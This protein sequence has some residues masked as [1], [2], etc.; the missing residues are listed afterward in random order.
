MSQWLS[1]PLPHSKESQTSCNRFS[2]SGACSAEYLC[3]TWGKLSTRIPCSVWWS[4]VLV[5]DRVHKEIKK[6]YK[7]HVQRWEGLSWDLTR[8]C[9]P[10]SQRHDL[11]IYSYLWRTPS[12]LSNRTGIYDPPLGFGEIMLKGLTQETSIR[13]NLNAMQVLIFLLN[14]HSPFIQY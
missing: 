12:P 5:G 14:I 11:Q 2:Y 4:E 13:L 1:S 10:T 9:R 7:Y 8:I 6:N 3:T